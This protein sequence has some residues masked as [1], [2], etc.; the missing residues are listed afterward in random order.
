MQWFV[1]GFGCSWSIVYSLL[2]RSACLEHSYY[3][4]RV[5]R[6]GNFQRWRL[7]NFANFST[8]QPCWIF[9]DTIIDVAFV[10]IDCLSIPVSSFDSF[11]LKREFSGEFLCLGVCAPP[12][13]EFIIWNWNWNWNCFLAVSLYLCVFS[14]H[15]YRLKVYC[16]VRQH[17]PLTTH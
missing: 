17:N 8:Y 9:G 4:T 14:T 10:P 3:C 13:L 12:A 7:L 16:L 1:M 11:L 6:T 15:N 2:W 5:S